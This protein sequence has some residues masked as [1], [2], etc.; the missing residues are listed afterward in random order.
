MDVA[1]GGERDL[2]LC[3]QQQMQ[4]SGRSKWDVEA[5]LYISILKS[6]SREVPVRWGCWTCVLA[7]AREMEGYT[8]IGALFLLLS[9]FFF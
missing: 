8:V 5:G 4:A 1:G 2:V 7:N 6:A 9:L 3:Q